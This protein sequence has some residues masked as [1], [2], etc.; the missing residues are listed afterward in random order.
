[1]IL[2]I[3]ATT[4][5][6]TAIAAPFVTAGLAPLAGIAAGGSCLSVILLLT[7]PGLKAQ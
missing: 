4:A 5:I 1:M 7:L 3:L 6:G 2:F